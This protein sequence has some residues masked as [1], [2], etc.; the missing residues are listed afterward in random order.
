MAADHPWK[1]VVRRE[2]VPE[3]GL[4]VDVTA[5]EETRD[6]VAHLAGLRSLPRLSAQFDVTRHGTGGLRVQGGVSATVGQTCVVTLEPIENEVREAVDLVF[7]PP[8]AV[9][10]IED[11]EA[12]LFDPAAEDQPE[13][14][15]DGHV[16][17]GAVAVEFLVLGVDP[18]PRKPG[19]V[20]ESPKAT[21]DDT[22][23]FAALEALKKGKR[24]DQ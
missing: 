12:E 4:R 5:D 23:P 15:E 21:D 24:D 22:H 7:V 20:F 16:D 1:I 10:P 9:R 14:L 8:T 3:S 13:P 11:A 6:A 2:D 18:Y 19:A 17:L